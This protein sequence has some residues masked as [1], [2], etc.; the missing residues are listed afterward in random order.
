MTAPDCWRL[1]AILPGPEDAETLAKL[2][3][4]AFPESATAWRAPDFRDLSPGSRILIAD[5]T[6]EAG[7]ILL[8]HAADEAEILTFAV[9][10]GLRRRGLG[11]ALLD[12]GEVAAVSAGARRLFLEVAADNAPARALYAAAGFSEAG[13]RKGYYRQADGARADA[14]VLA[15]PL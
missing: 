11:R 9:A 15:K 14:L 7:F 3:Q 12:A 4:A 8:G 10:P 6:L 5:E 1:R 2:S 13:R